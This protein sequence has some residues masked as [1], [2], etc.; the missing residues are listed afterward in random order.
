[1]QQGEKP[2][3]DSITDA[4]G[5]M[6]AEPKQAFITSSALAGP[7][8]QYMLP[9]LTPDALI[10]LRTTCKTLHQLVVTAPFAASRRTLET[11]LPPEIRRCATDSCSMGA[12]LKTQRALQHCFQAGAAAQLQTLQVLDLVNPWGDQWNLV[13]D[14]CWVP[15][16]PCRSV[17]VEAQNDEYADQV[18]LDTHNLPASNTSPAAR[19]FHQH[20]LTSPDP[21]RILLFVEDGALIKSRSGLAILDM[22]TL[23][24]IRTWSCPGGCHECDP[25]LGSELICVAV[26]MSGS[27]SDATSVVVLDQHP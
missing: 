14:P 10:V 15:E 20:A 11:L 7:L 1:M 19:W 24:L 9:Q 12:L 2:V 6:L 3:R 27:N 26:S 4:L 17:L 22:T 8:Q 16:S 5:Q 25:G 18:L 21:W 13:Y 23:E